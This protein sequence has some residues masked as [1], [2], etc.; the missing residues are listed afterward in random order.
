MADGI[1]E[2]MPTGQQRKP[3]EELICSWIS[4]ARNEIPAQMVSASFL[5]CG[6][7][8]NLDGSEDDLVYTSE[9]DAYKLFLFFSWPFEGRFFFITIQLSLHNKGL[10]EILNQH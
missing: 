5:K 7:T 9:E 2:F 4:Q 1:H 10:Q 8:N 3:S 6:I